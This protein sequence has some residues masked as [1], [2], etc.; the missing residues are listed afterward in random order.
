MFFFWEVIKLKLN[1]CVSDILAT[2]Y[3]FIILI[4]T[5][6]FFFHHFGHKNLSLGVVKKNNL[7]AMQ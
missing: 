6:Q 5:A 4:K 7:K 2:Y 3:L 1:Q